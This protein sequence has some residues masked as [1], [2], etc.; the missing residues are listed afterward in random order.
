MPIGIAAG[1]IGGIGSLAGGILG[2]N[3]SKKS[4]SQI[5]GAIQQGI[6][7]Q[8]GNYAQTQGNL[9]PF[10]GAGQSALPYLLAAYGLPGGN[11]GGIGQA[12]GAFQQT[13]GYQFPFQQGNLALNRQLASMGL[14]NSGAALRDASQYNQGLAGQFWQNYLSG[15]GGLVGAGQQGASTLGQIGAGVG[16]SVAQGYGNLGGAIGAGTIGQANALQSGFGGLIGS[17][18]LNPSFTNSLSSLLGGGQS[19]YTG[20]NAGQLIGGPGNP[21]YL[22]GQLGLGGDQYVP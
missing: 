16:S 22:Q 17:T 8:Q 1:L 7:F 2:G 9:Q 4:S 15:L 18:A 13:P 19:S 11:A 3:A 6:G 10:I 21:S 14:I 12:Y 20:P 5:A